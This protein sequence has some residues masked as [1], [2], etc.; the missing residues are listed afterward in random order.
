MPEG[1]EVEARCGASALRSQYA[2][3]GGAAWACP[4]PRPKLDRLGPCIASRPPPATIR[5]P[6]T[7]VADD[8]GPCRRA[9]CPGARRFLRA[10][11]RSA[12]LADLGPY[13]PVTK[14][15]GSPRVTF[16]RRG[17]A[18]VILCHRRRR[19]P[20]FARALRE[21]WRPA[22]RRAGRSPGRRG[23][24]RHNSPLTHIGRSCTRPARYGGAGPAG[25]GDGP[26]ACGAHANLD[27][28]ARDR[29]TLR[30]D[31]APRSACG[32]RIGSAWPAWAPPMRARVRSWPRPWPA[33]A[34]NAVPADARVE[35]TEGS[36]SIGGPELR[37]GFDR[38][39][40]RFHRK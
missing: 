37:H 9:P 25:P 30:I 21:D 27:P 39:C 6:P 32:L 5:P 22:A 35:H 28:S 34:C 14:S 18:T 11:W 36:R 7:A 26:I 33:G 3:A 38:L 15:S 40:L 17:R 13:E 10:T 8:R 23:D 1:A 29:R 2:R 4:W 12:R 20:M 19:W 24:F 31:R 16:C